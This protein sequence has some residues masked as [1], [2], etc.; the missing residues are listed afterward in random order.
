MSD[1]HPETAAPFSPIRWEDGHLKLLDQTRLPDT[2][3]WLDCESPEQVADAIRCL[4]VRGAPAIGVS[5]AYG[6]VLG[7]QTVRGQEGLAARFAEVAELLGRTRPTAVNL[8]WALERGRGPTGRWASTVPP[9]S[10]RARGC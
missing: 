5:A 7:I 9:C 6:L 1:A 10:G 4:A 8:R 3:A 2:E